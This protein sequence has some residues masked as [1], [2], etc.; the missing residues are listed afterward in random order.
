MTEH[1]PTPP[2]GPLSYGQLRQ[3][4]ANLNQNRISTR[5]QGNRNLSY[6]E[7]WD[8]RRAL[9]RI[10]GFGGFN[11]VAD[12]ARVLN[13]E[14]VTNSQGKPNVRITVMCRM[15][16][17][18]PQLGATY[19]EYAAS[20]QQGSDPG[21]VL[22]FAIKGL[23]LDTAIPTPDG[24]TTMGDLQVG[25]TVFDMDGKLTTVEMKSEVKHL[26]SY[27]LTFNDGRV[28]VCDEE[29]YWYAYN[30]ASSQLGVHNIVDLYRAKQEGR[31]VSIPLNGSLELPD[32]ELPVDPYLLGYWLGDGATASGRITVHEDDLPSLLACIEGDYSVSRDG[33]NPKVCCVRIGN[34]TP[35]SRSGLTHQLRQLG[36]LGKKMIPMEYMRASRGQRLALLQGLM[37][38][39][40]TVGGG[41]PVFTG[42]S[43]ILAEQV[44]ELIHSLGDR[45]STSVAKRSGF[46]KIVDSYTVTWTPSEMPFRLERKQAKVQLRKKRGVNRVTSIELIESVPTQCIGV[47]S[48]TKSYL[49]GEGMVPTHNTA[50]SDAL[51][52]CAINLGTQF[53]LSLYDNGATQDVVQMVLAPEQQWPRPAP[54]QDQPQQQEPA[55]A[56][57][58]QNVLGGRQVASEPAP[59]VTPEQHAANQA[60]LDRALNM[61]AQQQAQQDPQED[62]GP[63][64]LS[65]HADTNTGD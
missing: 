35:G 65:Q 60:L 43:H 2:P 36:V 14:A 30:G 31:S 50:E 46:G 33:R 23:A 20:S 52:R 21:E 51:K 54:D 5:K 59:G 12:E 40:G 41:R 1:T 42:T 34:S 9:I 10:F 53:G 32:A 45:P 7:A 16:L 44:A 13:T 56:A 48:E 39:D 25:D 6:L 38:S 58:V 27:R 55:G 11:A 8:V 22:D 3:L 19:A 62:T 47:A 29:H 28:I 24:W 64:V 37:D 17:H 61:K 15:T 4:T 63:A 18:V 26:P 49:A 57:V